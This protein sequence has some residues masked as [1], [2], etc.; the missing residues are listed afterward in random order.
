MENKKGQIE[1]GFLK[2]LSDATKID[3]ANSGW[4]VAEYYLLDL[5]D[6]LMRLGG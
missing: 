1:L 4:Q 5:S 2:G 3:L 6:R